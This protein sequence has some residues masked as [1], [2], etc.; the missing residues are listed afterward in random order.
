MFSIM[1]MASSTTKPVEM[2]SAMS[3]RLSRLK[4]SRYMAASV[5][6]S[7]SGTDRLGIKVAAMLR[8]NR[9]MTSTTR[10]TAR[11]SSNSTSATEARMVVV[12]SVSTRT[13]RAAGRVD[14]NCGNRAL[15]PSTTW[16]TFEPGW[17][18]TF[19]I[20]DGVRSAQA[21]SSVFS[22]PSSTVPM[23][24]RWTGRPFL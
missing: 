4:P 6:T 24:D 20:T 10:A 18:C 3:D 12:R 1:T 11:P 5:P 14:W 19:R 21:E 9:K 15:M 22:A 16:I 8:R 13:S 23:S 17:R 7:D 2:V